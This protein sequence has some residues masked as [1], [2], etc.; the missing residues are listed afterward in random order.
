MIVNVSK[1][2]L[3]NKK[4]NV[5]DKDSGQSISSTIYHY[6]NVPVLDIMHKYLE[7]FPFLLEKV[8]FYAKISKCES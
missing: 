8:I 3:V 1:S 7:T 2:I 6:I 4:G 5:N